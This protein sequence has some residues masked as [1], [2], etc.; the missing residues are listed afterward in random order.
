MTSWRSWGTL[1]R[2]PPRRRGLRWRRL[3]A[4]TL[5]REVP[6]PDPRHQ[7]HGSFLSF[8]DPNGNS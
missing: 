8:S 1:G 7:D 4:H 3:L 2:V 6:G 5:H